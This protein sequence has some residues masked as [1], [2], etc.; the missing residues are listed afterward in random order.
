MVNSIC[1]VVHNDL[2][3]CIFIYI[4]TLQVTILAAKFKVDTYKSYLVDPASSHMLVSKIKP[5]MSKY[6]HLYTVKLRTAHYI[7]NSFFD[8]FLLHG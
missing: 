2:F 3:V 4:Q 5:C 1:I 6:K 8:G 7:S